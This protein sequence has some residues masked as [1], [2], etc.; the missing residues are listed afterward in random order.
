MYSWEAGSPWTRIAVGLKNLHVRQIQRKKNP[1]RVI[2]YEN[3]LSDLEIS[4]AQT[5]WSDVIV[6][7]LKVALDDLVSITLEW[8]SSGQTVGR[9]FRG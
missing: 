4:W 2:Q 7:H 6:A 1:L 8:Q 5:S 9:N 3:I